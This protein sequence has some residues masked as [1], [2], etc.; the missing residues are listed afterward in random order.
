MK[1]NNCQESRLLSFIHSHKRKPRMWAQWSKTSFQND[2][3]LN[4]CL[5][6]PAS[7]DS[8]IH[9]QSSTSKVFFTLL[10]LLLRSLAIT[11]CAFYANHISQSIIANY[12]HQDTISFI[13]SN[14]E[15]ADRTMLCFY[16]PTYSGVLH[17][18]GARDRSWLVVPQEKCSPHK[19]S[20]FKFLPR[21]CSSILLVLFHL[22]WIHY[23]IIIIIIMD[24]VGARFKEFHFI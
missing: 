5:P 6:L 20:S 19:F 4:Q 11:D 23:P 1:A 24:F 7:I 8:V 17:I 2:T 16:I 9:E 14:L 18:L 10:L 15:F 22:D 3:L 12:F 21:F 13:W